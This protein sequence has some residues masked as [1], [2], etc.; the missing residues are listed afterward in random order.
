MV[1][2]TKRWLWIG[3]IA[4]V[5]GVGAAVLWRLRTPGVSEFEVPPEFADCEPSGARIGLKVEA[6]GGAELLAGETAECGLLTAD[7]PPASGRMGWRI[8][9]R[10]VIMSEAGEPPR[11]LVRIDA[12]KASTQGRGQEWS[13]LSSLGLQENQ[14]GQISS[15]DTGELLIT[16]TAIS[17]Q[18]ERP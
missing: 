9:F 2:G 8:G 6:A 7:A 15:T 12:F 13:H 16:V 3:L 1:P 4:V 11:P 14:V 5:G 10:P 17:R 18:G